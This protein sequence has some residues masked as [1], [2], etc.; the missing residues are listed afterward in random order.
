VEWTV[1]EKFSTGIE[2]LD[3]LTDGGFPRGSVD[4]IVQ[5]IVARARARR[6]KRVFID[7]LVA[8]RDSLVIS[9]RMPYVINA[10]SMRLG[11]IG[12]T[13]V[14]TSEIPELQIEQTQLPSDELSAMVDNVLLLNTGRRAH[15]FRRYLSVMKLR[16]S[17]FDPRTQEFHIGGTGIAFGPDPRVAPAAA[18]D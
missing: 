2:E 3:P 14:Y 4:E 6:G 17:D 10:L 9:S 13:V 16:D 1:I 5:D 11:A 8:I 12:A 7:G 18:A 15:A